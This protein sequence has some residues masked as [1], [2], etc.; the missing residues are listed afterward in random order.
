[1]STAAAVIVGNEVLTGKFADENG[2]YL[3]GRLRTLGC[4]LVRLVTIPDEVR[5]I[6]DEVRRCSAAA[7]HVF[8]SGGV[9]P[10]HDDVTFEGIAGAFG[11]GLELRAEL[12]DVVAQFGMPRNV[13]TERMAR[14]PI[15]A[16]LLFHAMPSYP[17]VR[18]NNVYVLPGVPKLFKDKFERIAERFAGEAVA[19]ARV[20][21][22]EDEWH[23]AERLT[24]VADAWPTVAIGSYPRWGEGPFH[25]ILTLESRDHEALAAAEAA[26]RRT[27]RAIPP[28]G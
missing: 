17:V 27:I 5:V 22:D 23:L 9:G 10:T 21:T 15:G 8:T 19:V 1:M 6:A 26:I 2:P 13:G 11:V 20:Y 4:D 7:D 24:A 16:E 3:I 12:L 28:P 25:V 14:V 18:M